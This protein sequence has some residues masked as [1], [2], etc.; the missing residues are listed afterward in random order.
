MFGPGRNGEGVDTFG[1]T[2]A[3]LC[4]QFSAALDRDVIDKTGIRGR[5]DIHL[6]LPDA[7]LGGAREFADPAVPDTPE[8]PFGAISAAVKK[9][10]LK[11]ESGKEPG[12]FLVIDHVERPGEN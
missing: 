10:G 1:Q 4:D 2:M 8:D 12:Q 6:D 9:L 5:F 11:L 3:G 7:A